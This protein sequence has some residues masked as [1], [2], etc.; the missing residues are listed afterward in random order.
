MLDSDERLDCTYAEI[1]E[2]LPLMT[3]N[4]GALAFPRKRWLD[5]N[6]TIQTE[7]NAYPDYQVRLFKNNI[8]YTWKREVHEYFDGCEVKHLSY[9]IIDHFHDV[10]KSPERLKERSELYTRLAAQA[11]VTVEGGKVL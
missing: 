4:V 2:L 9:P 5:I 10:F 6:K 8:E 11:G 1:R 3:G 7:I